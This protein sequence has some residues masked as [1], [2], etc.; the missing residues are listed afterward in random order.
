MID[1]SLIQQFLFECCG[2]RTGDDGA[3]NLTVS[4]GTPAYSYD[5]DNDGTGDNDDTE[6]LNGLTKGSYTVIVTDDNGCSASITAE[7]DGDVGITDFENESGIT[8][9]PNPIKDRITIELDKI[10]ENTQ[11]S[12]T[13]AQ[14]KVVYS[15]QN[16]NT[17]RISVDGQEWSKGIYFLNVS[18]NNNNLRV[19]KVVKQ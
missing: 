6:D 1:N 4:G 16:I 15:N 7:V 2:I 13:N 12:I 17:N 14:G 10:T 5:W 8:I 18:D 9:Y 11:I 19:I 3:I